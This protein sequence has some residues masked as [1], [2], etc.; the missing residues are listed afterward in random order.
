MLHALCVI[1]LAVLF[2]GGPVRLWLLAYARVSFRKLP[3]SFRPGH[4]GRFLVRERD[5]D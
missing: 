2:S 5:D 3:L 4:T 1:A